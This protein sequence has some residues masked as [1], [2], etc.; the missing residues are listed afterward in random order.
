MGVRN[1]NLFTCDT[2]IAVAC[3]VGV[4][5]TIS[6]GACA[7]ARLVVITRAGVAVVSP[8]PIFQPMLKRLPAVLSKRA[9]K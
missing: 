2:V 7:R 9:A 3:T 4:Y 6:L 5:V 8:Q 1:G